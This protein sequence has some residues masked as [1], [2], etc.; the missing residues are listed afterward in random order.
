MGNRNKDRFTNPTI[1]QLPSS[2]A[3]VRSQLHKDQ[4]VFMSQNST[5]FLRLLHPRKAMVDL[6]LMEYW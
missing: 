1:S 6:S 2:A 4:Q 5:T 3:V